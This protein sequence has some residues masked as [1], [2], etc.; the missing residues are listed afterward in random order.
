[1]GAAF[2][3]SDE[4]PQSFVLTRTATAHDVIINCMWRVHCGA[5][6]LDVCVGEACP[7]NGNKVEAVS[8]A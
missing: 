7:R 1:V 6:V 5:A 4:F 2:A 8:A 3:I